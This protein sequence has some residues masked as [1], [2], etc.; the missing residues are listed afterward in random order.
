MTSVFILCLGNNTS[1]TDQ[2]ATDLAQSLGLQNRGLIDQVDADVSKPGIYHTTV[3]DLSSGDIVHLSEKFQEIIMLDQPRAEWSHWKLLQSTYKIMVALEEQ[4]A[5]TKFRDN[6]NVRSMQKI[7]GMVKNNPSWCIYPWMNV[8]ARNERGISLCARSETIVSKNLDLDSWKASTIREDIKQK[9]LQGEKIPEHCSF[10]YNYEDLGIE[11]YR[12]YE[13]RD[14]LNQ[15]DIDQVEDLDRLQTPMYYEIYWSNHC[16][17]KCRGCTPQRS[18]AIEKEFRKFKISAPVP[19]KV[20]RKYPKVDLVDIDGLVRQS[21]VYVSGGEPVIMP[22]TIEFMQRCID[23]GR[24]DFE[25]TMS[26]NGVKIPRKFVELSRHFSNLN[27]SFS[28]DGYGPV[29]DYWRSGSRWESIVA[30]MHRMKDLGH[31]ISINHVP[32]IYNVTNMHLLFEWLDQEFPQIA[33]YLQINHNGIQS[34]Y[35]HPNARAVVDSMR[36]CQQTK[37]YWSDGKSCRTSID[38]IHDYYIKNPQCD[39]ESLRQFFEYNDQLDQIR[40]VRLADYIP[41][42]EACRSLIK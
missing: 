13:S 1:D 30:N 36:R 29:N 3:A 5:N 40:G 20:A 14:W 16:N 22:E 11:S 27:L 4:G 35:N 19:M 12:Q 6:Q 15:L 17:L 18:S 26:T 9:M 32:G 31:K 33:L 39:L 28:I 2:Q 41:E 42:L 23:R 8:V 38:R 7:E 25:L 37:V 10:C 24:T 34:A 21:R